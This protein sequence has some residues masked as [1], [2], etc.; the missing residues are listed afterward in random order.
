[1]RRRAFRAAA[2]TAAFAVLSF[3][4]QSTGSLI[5]TVVDQDGSVT[6]G[7]HVTLTL[8]A[9]SAVR[10]AV[11]D[12]S[13][14]VRFEALLPGTYRLQVNHSGFKTLT[15][16]EIVL[17]SSESRDLGR[18]ALQVG[19]VNERIEVTAEATPVQTASSE[20]ADS[21]TSA[22]LENIPMKGRD[23]YGELHLLPGV[24][25]IA[26]SRDL[27][28][29]SEMGTISING[30]TGGSISPAVDGATIQ[31]MAGTSLVFVTP[32]MDAIDEVR[33]LANGYQAE[34]GR[35]AGATINFVTKSGT[36]HFHGTL[37]WD[38]RNEGLNANTFFNNRQ[39][40]PRAIYR[41]LI[42]GG[43]LGG[44]LY[45][46]KVMPRTWKNKFFFFYSPEYSTSKQPTNTAIVN[47]P[48]ALER[49][50]NFSQTFYATAAAPTT[51]ILLKIT[52]P[53]TGAQFPGNVIPA[54]RIVPLGQAM[55][56]LL[57]PPNGYVNPAQPYSGNASYSATPPFKKFDN[58]LRT[59]AN[60]TSHV[61]AY[62]RMVRDIQDQ[63]F[64]NSVTPGLGAYLQN[65]PGGTYLGHVAW[66]VK[67]SLV[68]ETQVVYGWTT[69][70]VVQHTSPADSTLYHSSALDPPRLVPYPVGKKVPWGYN[71]YPPFLPQ[72]FFTGGNYAL[73]VPAG[74]TSTTAS[75]N[76]NGSGS[77]YLNG[78]HQYIFR[79]DVTWIEGKHTFKGG[80][81][82]EHSSDF[83]EGGPGS[84][85]T[86]TYNFGS[87]PTNPFD[88]GD[89]Y[90]NALLG[91]V[92]QYTEASS[93]PY[94]QRFYIA[95]EWYVQ[96]NWKVTP[97]LTL[98]IGV[99]FLHNGSTQDQSKYSAHFLP[100]AY[101]STNA[102]VLFLPA[103]KV[104]GASCSAANQE[105]INPLNG[106]VFPSSAIAQVV[107]GTNAVDGVEYPIVHGL[108]YP[109]VKLQP[110]FGFAWNIF[111]DNKTV[112]RG[113]MSIAS[114]RP[115]LNNSM[116]GSYSPPVTYPNAVSNTSL[117]AIS[118]QAG[119]SILTPITGAVGAQVPL[120]TVH[121]WNLTFERAVGF[122]TVVNI[123]YVGT[124]DRHAL[125]TITQNNIP[126]G[127]YVLPSN[128]FAGAEVNANLLRGQYPGI[129]VVNTYCG[130]VST[131]NYNAL[132]TSVKHRFT[133][134]LTFNG[135]YQ[136]S[137]ALGTSAWDP[138]HLGVP[139]P[140]AYGGTITLPNQRQFYYGPTT[141]DRSQ[142]A[143]AN[144]AYQLPTAGFFG[145]K[146]SYLLG[147][148]T[149]SG[150]T[151]FSTGAAVSPACS[152]TAAFPANDP[153]WTG[154]ITGT[155]GVRC[156][157]T[158]DW[159]NFTQS[160]YTNFNA[161]AFSYPTG[162]TTANPAPNFGNTGLG[163]MRQ[164]SWWNQDLTITKVFTLGERGRTVGISLQAYN[165]LNHTEFNTI[166]TTYTFNA[167]GVNTNSTTGQATGAQ[168]NRQVV[169][170]AKFQ[171]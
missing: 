88:T 50:G 42:L 102:P 127:A 70:G 112:I 148:W 161:A 55:L 12:P 71:E 132:Q 78:D 133:K 106:A 57:L 130:C 156:Q 105:A 163:I 140:T 73:Y 110:R 115:S 63:G 82:W 43:S 67:P 48:T 167:A 28:V 141:T 22:Q 7:A 23:P 37:H 123:A 51:P 145:K 14:A 85:F 66:I 34:Y 166:G 116:I 33:V 5:G 3:G 27:S 125:Q 137:K 165:V 60:I 138:Y 47:E 170:T 99:R 32:N 147:G 10:E 118:G 20:R 114:Q 39:A 30:L 153:T 134:G 146:A 64:A 154:L 40:V 11:S 122:S 17:Q 21:V 143:G 103:C 120:E 90:A 86:G 9:E 139:I 144:F 46:P 151:S 164:P 108:S 157:V 121:N 68:N 81:Y 19:G 119:Q 171:F 36:S 131:L 109:E 159:K 135:N 149:L 52:D 97:R 117:S 129:G 6:P 26:A 61:T 96:D 65:T 79:D 155:T 16:D 152:S 62:F 95:T 72:L 2:L 98:D 92:T 13:G 45:V 59:D 113:S 169:L 158:G 38:H 77:Q 126:F 87:A 100:S 76:P 69:Q 84:N 89:G 35:D 1:M 83:D 93:R 29:Y 101:T 44:P 53:N 160:F 74:S 56:G 15:M 94:Q 49:A 41:Y 104:A 18:L 8:I 58:V 136:F 111:G 150:V 80:V 107:P 4:Q 162:G 31:Q 142:Y 124:F 168:P 128:I 91:V 25:E 54:S 75:W 24:V